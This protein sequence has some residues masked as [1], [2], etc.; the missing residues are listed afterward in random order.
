MCEHIH[1]PLGQLAADR[2]G[3]IGAVTKQP[4]RAPMLRLLIDQPRCLRTVLLTGRGDLDRRDQRHLAV[5]DGGVDL[6]PVEP[7]ECHEVC[8]RRDRTGAPCPQ[9]KRII[10]ASL[11]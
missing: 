5:S 8:V 10:P 1:L 9:P 2:A 4:L 7:R 3:A 6:I 11:F